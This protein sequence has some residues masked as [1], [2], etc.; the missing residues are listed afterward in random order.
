MALSTIR[1]SLSTLSIMPLRIMTRKNNTT[2]NYREDTI[3]V[4]ITTL[5]ITKFYMLLLI[6]TKKVVKMI[7]YLILIN[8]AKSWC[9]EAV[10]L[11]MCD[12]SMN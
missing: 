5:S 11:V 10:F 8:Y 12:P 4:S 7:M 1:L 6:L 2:N 9:A 3:T